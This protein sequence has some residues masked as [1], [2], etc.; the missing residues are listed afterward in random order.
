MS[1]QSETHTQHDISKP[2]ILLDLDD[3]ILDFKKSERRAL[4]SA[5]K[6]MGI[7]YSEETLNRYSDINL[8]YWEQLE[9]GLLTREQVLLG[10]FVQLLSEIQEDASASSLRDIYEN[11][12]SKGHFFV[13]GAPELL[14][15][16]RGNYRLFLVSNG[17]ASVQKGRLESAGITD[18]F[19]QIFISQ[20][21][22]AE[23]PSKVFFDRCFENIPGFS[24]RKCIIVGD[25]LTSD[26]R[27]GI[28]AGIKTCWFNLRNRPR[29]PDI[30]PDYT[31]TSLEE[32]HAVLNSAF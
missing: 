24:R 27:G 13:T 4:S 20:I 5:L 6:E 2:C 25:S 17:T 32:L 16:L 19:E 8:K 18:C 30:V 3:T 26:I 28:N 1:E 21:I 23:K 7:H 22:G 11:K 15:D 31:I 9:E 10:R 29:N 14:R 12:L